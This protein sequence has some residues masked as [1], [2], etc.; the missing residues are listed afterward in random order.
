MT[1]GRMA[2]VG[3]GPIG[4]ECLVRALAEGW[5]AELYERGRI[6]ENIRAWGH[7]RMF[8]P[9][10]M[11][12]PTGEGFSG[13][14]PEELPTGLEYVT[15]RLEPIA[16]RPGIAGRIH[17]SC[18]VAAIARGE[19][20]KG[21]AIGDSERALRPFRLLIVERGRE[22]YV[23]AEVVVDASGSFAHANWL[24]EGGIPAIG[25]REL[26]DSIEHRLPDVRGRDRPRFMGRLTLVVG[27]GHSAASAIAWLADLAADSPRTRVTWITRSD[28]ARPVAEIAGDPLAERARVSRAA[29][30]LADHGASWLV[31]E[32]GARVREVRVVKG[33]VAVV[34]SDGG[35]TRAIEGDQVLALVGYRPD[36][37]FLRELQIQTC[38]ATE[39]TYALAAALLS[40]AGNGVDCLTVG[41]DLDARTLLHPEPGFFVIGAKS[42]GRNPNFLIRAGLKQIDDL[43]ALLRERMH[44]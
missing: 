13:L 32:R 28:A 15:H 20:R 27:H 18:E 14:D 12:L 34:V 4:L 38:W 1:L 8:S 25:E 39:G 37:S 44:P 16:R 9:W 6:G 26:G 23:E 36:L 22:R 35:T 41:A 10:S 31:R 42:Y 2:I 7:V 43:F 30:D 40:E 21:D 24:G 29:N 11:N 5:D 3:G 33:K 17:E 19:L